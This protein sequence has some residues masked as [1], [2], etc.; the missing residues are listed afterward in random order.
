FPLFERLAAKSLGV[1]AHNQR[2]RHLIEERVSGVPVAVVPMG[3]PDPSADPLPERDAARRALGVA[4]GTFLVGLFGFMTPIKRPLEALAAF[5]AAARRNPAARMVV[6]GE[7]GAS[8]DL[9]GEARRLGVGE[10]LTLTGYVPYDQVKSWV[11]A[12]DVFVNLR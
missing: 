5:A 9:D 12:A 1:L 4:P 3:I 2:A 6:V 7:V 8:I 10:R 11:A